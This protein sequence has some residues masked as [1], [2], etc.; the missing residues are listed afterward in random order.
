VI[1]ITFLSI[2]LINLKQFPDTLF[3]IIGWILIVLIAISL[4]YL[5]VTTLPAVIKELFTK[6]KPAKTKKEKT[7]PP[8]RKLTTAISKSNPFHD[9]KEGKQENSYK[10]IAN[11]K[12]IKIQEKTILI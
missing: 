1:L 3:T 8:L 5:W 4:I 2:L 7:E 11:N 9:L 12:S 6:K 10:E